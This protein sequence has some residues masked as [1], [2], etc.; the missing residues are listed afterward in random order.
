M[1]CRT[2]WQKKKKLTFLKS[3]WLLVTLK[4]CEKGRGERKWEERENCWEKV[5]GEKVVR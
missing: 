1:S 4:T 2:V 3:K 5:R